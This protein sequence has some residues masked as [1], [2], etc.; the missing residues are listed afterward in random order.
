MVASN[1]LVEMY[2]K[3]KQLDEIGMKFLGPVE[4]RVFSPGMRVDLVVALVLWGPTN[5]I[6]VFTSKGSIIGMDLILSVRPKGSSLPLIHI[7][8]RLTNFSKGFRY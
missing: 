6:I 3:I 8:R 4:Y 5:H 2:Q 7:E 1:S